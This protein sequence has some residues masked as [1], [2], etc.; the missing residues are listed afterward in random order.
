MQQQRSGSSPT[1]QKKEALKKKKTRK[2][3]RHQVPLNVS[4]KGK[5]EPD[6]EDHA[7]KK[8]GIWSEVEKTEKSPPPV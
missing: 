7:E 2:G 4:R 1:W 6:T 3:R 8:R 5:K